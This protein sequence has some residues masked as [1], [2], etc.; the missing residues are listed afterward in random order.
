[1]TE[2]YIVLMREPHCLDVWL[3]AVDASPTSL[4]RPSFQRE[5]AQK[6]WRIDG[7]AV[8]I[9]TCLCTSLHGGVEGMGRAGAGEAS[10]VQ[11]WCVVGSR[12]IVRVYA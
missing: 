10:R 4:S 11:G 7:Q 5:M 8:L 3:S 9:K 2:T 1:V 12:F 6:L